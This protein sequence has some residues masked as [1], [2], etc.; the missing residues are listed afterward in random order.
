M[1]V[2][3][4]ENQN[5]HIISQ[6]YQSALLESWELNALHDEGKVPAV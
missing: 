1:N 5:L 2:T 4:S 6:A 3:P